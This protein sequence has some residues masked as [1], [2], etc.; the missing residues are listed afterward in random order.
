VQPLDGPPKFA[1]LPGAPD[2]AAPQVFIFLPERRA[3]L[4]LVRQA[5]PN[6]RVQEIHR[7]DDPA[8]TLLFIAYRVN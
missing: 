4:D 3:E 7:M 1:N 5:Y 8:Q 2:P 6:G